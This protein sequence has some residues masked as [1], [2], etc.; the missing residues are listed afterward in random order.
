[1]LD[2]VRV[3][4]QGTWEKP[5]ADLWGL[6]AHWLGE[7]PPP[8]LTADDAVGHLVRRYLTGFGPATPAEVANWC[9]MRLGDVA[10]ALERLEPLRR[11]RARADGAELV[12]LPRLPLPGGEVPA[13]VRLL[14]TW[15]ATLLTHARRAGVIREEDRE[16]IFSVRYPQSFRTFTV[17]GTVEGTWRVEADGTVTTDAWRPLARPAAEALAAEVARFEA[18]LRDD[19]G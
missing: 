16:R 3:P 15:D 9:G 5:R 17:D 13:P 12:D 1:M 4:P 6:A 8:D 14:P 2:L 19:G 18:W 10:P 11:F 7:A